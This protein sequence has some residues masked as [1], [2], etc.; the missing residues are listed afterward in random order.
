MGDLAVT[1]DQ[2]QLVATVRDFCAR[3][4]APKIQAADREGRHDPEIFAKLASIGLPGVCFPQR[5]GG[6]GLDYLS[7]GLAC[8]EL[9]YVDTVFRTV[10]SVHVGLVGMGLYTW[11]TE[12]QKQR[13]LRPM[14]AGKKL[15]CYGLTEPNAGSDAASMLSTARRHGSG[16]VLNGQKIWVSDANTADYLLVFAKDDPKAGAGGVAGFMLDRAECGKAV[17][18]EPIEDRL[19]IRAG[20][21]GSIFMSDLEVPE[22]NRI[23][24]EGDGFK[25]AMSCLDNGRFTAAAGATGTGRPCLDASVPYSHQRKPFGQEIGRYQLVQQ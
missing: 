22:A 8:E 21:V 12:E 7:L 18:T 6:H 10:L 24:D 4:F 23:G 20:D 16:Y 15:A 3:E 1:A 11:A 5:Y 14:A 19:G 25:I 2:E 9:E 13:W 17:R